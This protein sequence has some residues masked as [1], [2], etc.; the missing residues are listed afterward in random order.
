M[1][2]EVLEKMQR[3]LNDG[4]PST[5]SVRSNLA[6]AIQDQQNPQDIATSCR[7]SYQH[8]EFSKVKETQLLMKMLNKL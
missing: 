2:K 8:S 1:F 5:I 3:I 4:H 6:V 7:P